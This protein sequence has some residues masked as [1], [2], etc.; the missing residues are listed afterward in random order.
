MQNHPLKIVSLLSTFLVMY[1]PAFS[2]VAPG[3]SAPKLVAPALENEEVIELSPFIVSSADSKGWVANNSLAGSRL[4]T[5]LEDIPSQM[6]IFTMEF[7]QD[8]GFTSAEDAAIYSLNIE[9]SNEFVQ[10]ADSKGSGGNTLRVR[11]LGQARRTREFFATDTRSDNYNLERLTLASGP[12]PMTFGIGAPTGAVD[13]SLARPVMNRESAKVKT[14][15]DSFGGLR[16][17]FH[18]NTTL[19][20][21]KLAFLGAVL[22]DNKKSD[23]QPSLG[24]DRRVYGAFL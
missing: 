19:V 12:N 22:A 4:K 3:V 11:G 24:K 16:V 7:M 20:R 10:V 6:E 15:M 1:G 5:K 14:Q 18:L 2:Q 13:S 23:I 21:D 17:E 8:F 9:N